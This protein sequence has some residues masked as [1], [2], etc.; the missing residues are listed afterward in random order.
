MSSQYGAPARSFVRPTVALALLPLAAL[1]CAGKGDVSGKVT[2]Q[3]KPLV[4]GTVQFEGS[5]HLVKQ[6]NINSD[7]TYTVRGVATGEAKAAV[8]SINP[9]SSDF[10][11]RQ[12]EGGPPPKP[13]PEVKGWFPVPEKYDTP[14]KSGLTYTINRGE[15]KIDIELK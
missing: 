3:G 7:G 8:S 10:Q 11:V 9:K 12:A 5:D 14:F 6:G 4:W 13:R 1:G 2:Y 15:N